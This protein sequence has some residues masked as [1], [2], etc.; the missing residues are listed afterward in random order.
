MADGPLT[1]I[2]SDTS[3]LW[4]DG[5]HNPA[6]GAMLASRAGELDGPS[7]APN[8]RHDELEGHGRFFAAFGGGGCL[9][10]G[11]AIPGEENS[12]SAADLVDAALIA[13]LNVRT[14]ADIAA[15]EQIQSLGDGPV[16]V[17]ICGSLYLAGTVLACNEETAGSLETP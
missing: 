17:L 11:V 15:L 8:W 12:L 2:L 3:E 5:G 10:L 1:A 16:R 14:A 9:F 6:A 13:G 4:L 7:L